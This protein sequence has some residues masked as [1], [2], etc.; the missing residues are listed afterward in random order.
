MPDDAR[1]TRWLA[2]WARL[3]GKGDPEA[4]HADLAAR[5]SE[6]HRAYHTL[7][8]VAECLTEFDGA[9]DLATYP[10]EV[11][12]AIWFHDAVYDPHRHDSEVQSAEMARRTALA[13]DVRAASAKRVYHLILATRHQ[14]LPTDPDQQLIVDVDLASL[15]L[16]WERFEENGRRIR[17]EY[18]HVPEPEFRTGRAAVLER[19]LRRPHIYATVP[20]RRRYEERA[21]ANLERRVSQLR[22]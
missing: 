7:A 22:R 2:L 3:G 15:A 14:A 21:R 1:Q 11:E 9:R 6:P 4:V 8:H 13:A 18:A 19:L 17:Q 5:Y 16:P 12:L 20:F 10:D